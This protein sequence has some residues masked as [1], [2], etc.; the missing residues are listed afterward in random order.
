[1]AHNEFRQIHKARPLRVNEALTIQ[2]QRR[3]NEMAAVNDLGMSGLKQGENV[4]VHC[5]KVA[6]PQT[7]LQ[8][9]EAW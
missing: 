3:A 7:A 5:D 4:M 8:A 9:T 1:M 6:H 2:A